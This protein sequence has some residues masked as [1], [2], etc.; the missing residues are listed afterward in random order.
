MKIRKK[1]RE[2]KGITIVALIITVIVLLILAGITINSATSDDGIIKEAKQ[3]MLE[4]RARSVEEAK[5]LWLINKREENKKSEESRNQSLNE[6]LDE[7]IS[8]KVLKKSEKDE[9]IGNAEKG[10]EAKGKI[11]IGDRT[12]VF[13]EPL[14]GDIY[15]DDMIGQEVTYEAGGQKKWIIFGKNQ[16]GDILLTTKEPIEQGFYLKGG[17]EKWLTYEDDLN[18][19]C[20][21]YG[22]EIQDREIMSRSMTIDDVNYV[23]EY[24][25]PEVDTYEFVNVYNYANKKVNYPY[26]DKY[27]EKYWKKPTETAKRIDNTWYYYYLNRTNQTIVYSNA[28][29]GGEQVGNDILNIDRMK[30]IWGGDTTETAYSKYLLASNSVRIQSNCVYFGITYVGNNTD[31]NH[32][33]GTF[34]GALC[35]SNPSQTYDY[36]QSNGWYATRPVVVIPSEIRVEKTANETYDIKY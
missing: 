35:A 31:G 18:E 21:K 10:I 26:P 22:S 32:E 20:S 5:N 16:S 24:T 15:T 19:A 7:L 36:Q 13:N 12:I 27:S 14:I 2:S 9:I 6:L 8:E 11:T 25:K 30:Y 33:V 1:S 23:A 17:A 29:S 34:R 3:A 4:D 28:K